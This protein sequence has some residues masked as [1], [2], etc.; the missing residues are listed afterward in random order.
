MLWIGVTPFAQLRT[1]L[2]TFRT[3]S[4]TRAAQNLGITQP[5]A[6]GHIRALEDQ[7]GRTLFEREARGVRPTAAA[8]ELA[9]AISGAFDAI[10]GDYAIMRLRAEAVEGTIRLAGPSEFMNTRMGAPLAKLAEVGLYARVT[11]GGRDVIYAAL[12]AGDADLAIT[13]SKP[14][15]AELGALPIY[16]EELLPV[17][18]PDWIARALKHKATLAAALEHAPLSY[19]DDLNHVARLVEHEGHDPG[20]LRPK[21]VVPDF[22][23]VV[24]LAERGVSWAVV[25]NYLA[26]A[27]IARGALSILRTEA[28]AL[29]NQLYLVWRK[30][31]LRHPRVS[32]ARQRLLELLGKD[33]TLG[34]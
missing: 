5:A 15:Q 34:R 2:E 18:S 8:Q 31:S 11:L 6:S 23:F 12:D 13:A 20:R 26:E 27:A 29:T 30:S 24:D 1:F 28:S 10:E 33:F 17:A 7:I 16:Q 21:V 14:V 9:A 19:D 22:R 3:G 32:F 4:V 25:P